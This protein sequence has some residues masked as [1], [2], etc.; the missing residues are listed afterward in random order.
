MNVSEQ[1]MRPDIDQM[2]V[3]FEEALKQISLNSLHVQSSTEVDT[4]L[5]DLRDGIFII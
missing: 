3:D 2:T 1:G 4:S 5:L